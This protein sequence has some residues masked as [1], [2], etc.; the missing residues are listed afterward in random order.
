MTSSRYIVCSVTGA[1]S[2]GG[3]GRCCGAPQWGQAMAS[4]L[5][6]WPHSLHE[7]RAIYDTGVHWAI[8]RI[9]AFCSSQAYSLLLVFFKAWSF[10]WK[11]SPGALAPCCAPTLLVPSRFLTLGIALEEAQWRQATVSAHIIKRRVFLPCFRNAHSEDGNMFLQS[12]RRHLDVLA[13]LQ[14][15]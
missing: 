10:I 2:G 11:R 9:L 3:T 12:R 13:I 6:N 5:T 4:V 8:R 7:T 15:F 14:R 1:I